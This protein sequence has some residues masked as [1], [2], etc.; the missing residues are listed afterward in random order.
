MNIIC[1]ILQNSA[2]PALSLPPVALM[3]KPELINKKSY[4][5]INI[6]NYINNYFI[7]AVLCVL[8]AELLVFALVVL[9][10]VGEASLLLQL[11]VLP[12]SCGLVPISLCIRLFRGVSGNAHRFQ[13]LLCCRVQ[14]RTCL[15]L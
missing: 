11:P 13:D 6:K 9:V 12:A 3:L 5:I 1:N 10:S 8:A 7:N 15:I 4:I 14:A 2:V